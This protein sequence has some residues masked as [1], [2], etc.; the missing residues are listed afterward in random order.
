MF[1]VASLVFLTRTATNSAVGVT[2][3]VVLGDDLV[4]FLRGRRACLWLDLDNSG[5]ARGS[6]GVGAEI[7]A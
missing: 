4:L 6:S 1:A 3:S 5:S 2:V 7:Y